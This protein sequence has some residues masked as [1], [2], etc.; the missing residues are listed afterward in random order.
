MTVCS[1]EPFFVAHSSL[2]FPVGT[3]I[4]CFQWGFENPLA[5]RMGND[6]PVRSHVFNARSET[7]D[8][9]RMFSGLVHKKRCIVL[10]D[11]F[12]EW[13]TE[14]SPQTGDVA[15]KQVRL[16]ECAQFPVYVFCWWSG[17][18]SLSLDVLSSS[19]V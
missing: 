8:E 17:R 7:V 3:L 9:K 18:C 4:L 2:L 19:L 15:K 14:Y 12:F 6:G 10:V 1:M 16:R 11:G 13:K 5:G